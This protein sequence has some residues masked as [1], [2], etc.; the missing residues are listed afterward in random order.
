M[1]NRHNDCKISKVKA[2][3]AQRGGW[4][5]ILS[6]FHGLAVSFEKGTR[7]QPCP[8]TNAGKTK[9]RWFNDADETGGGYHN[10][11]GALPDG[12]DVVAWY[13][14]I[15]K[16][17][18]MNEIIRLCGGDLS[19]VS[20]TEM[21]NVKV[22]Q[23]QK[24]VS[25]YTPE[26][27][28]KNR[29]VLAK[30][31]SEAK[32]IAGTHAEAYLRNRGIK[33][34]LSSINDL[35]F[36]PQL[37]F[38]NEDKQGFD[39]YPGMLAMVRDVNGKPVTMHRTFLHPNQP[40]KAPVSNPKLQFK[41]IDDVRG[42]A[43]R[44]DE[45][46]LMPDGKKLIGV[47]EGIENALSVREASGCPMWVGISD[48][49]MEM[50][51]FP[52]DIGHVVVW[53]DVEPSGAGVAAAERMVEAL[54]K[55]GIKVYILTPDMPSDKVDWNDVYQDNRLDLFPDFLPPEL[56]VQAGMGVSL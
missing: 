56:K 55:K 14:G 22:K 26:E 27:I 28:E 12:I 47:S 8:K 38:W 21:R 10:D 46:I 3:V 45:P 19:S 49:L 34:D 36:H 23:S 48:R 15:S 13:M 24:S 54:S 11:V 39:K 31:K 9:F 37:S 5:N 50:I 32:V 2:L 20:R 16:N 51:K 17:E 33:A 52:E 4:K 53:A 6:S 30:V 44:I 40:T 42:C 25:R 43:I 41:G 29:K 18:A 35:G 1:Y 7:Q